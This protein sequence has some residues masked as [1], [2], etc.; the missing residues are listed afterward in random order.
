[1]NIEAADAAAKWLWE[2]IGKHIF[3]QSKNLVANK[4][5]RIRIISAIF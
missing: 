3:D 5:R 1:M 2:T 4:W